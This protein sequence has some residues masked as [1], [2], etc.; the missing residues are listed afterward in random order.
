ME[1]NN[2]NLMAIVLAAAVTILACPVIVQADSVLWGIDAKDDQLFCFKDARAPIDSFIDFGSLHYRSGEVV[3]QMGRGKNKADIKAFAVSSDG[4]AYMV[5]DK[6]V[7]KYEDNGLLMSIDL[8]NVIAGDKNIVNIIGAIDVEYG[9]NGNGKGKGRGKGEGRGRG[10][11]ASVTGLAFSPDGELMM[12]LQSRRA[13]SKLYT[14]DTFVGADGAVDASLI[15]SIV[16]LKKQAFAA[17]DITFDA[18]GNMYVVDD[19]DKRSNGT[20]YKVNARNGAIMKVIDNNLGDYGIADTEIEGLAYDRA[21]KIMVAWDK[22]NDSLVKVNMLKEGNNSHI[23]LKAMGLED[24][25]A[26]SFQATAVPEPGTLGLLAIGSVAFF[27]RRR[28]TTSLQRRI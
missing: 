26:M 7:G 24:V 1:R 22:K 3:T 25:K 27:M 8:N 19:K 13:A 10:N 4:I 23:K 16:G 28:Q 18:A 11:V 20:L 9:S 14:I 2:I 6:G 15:G 12:L 21:S 17:E 5:A